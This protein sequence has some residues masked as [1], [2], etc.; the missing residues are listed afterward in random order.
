MIILPLSTRQAPGKPAKGAERQTVSQRM[1][2]CT[3]Y[4]CVKNPKNQKVNPCLSIWF[5]QKL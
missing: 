3:A 4:S 2:I 1:S 5:R